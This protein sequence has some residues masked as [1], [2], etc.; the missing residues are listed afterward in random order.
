MLNVTSADEG[1]SR[2]LSSD[3][4]FIRER[5]MLTFKLAQE[6]QRL[7]GCKMQIARED[8]FSVGF[9]L[10]LRKNS[11]LLE[12]FNSALTLMIENGLVARWRN[13]YWPEKNE[14]TEC[15]ASS[16]SQ[17]VPLSLKHFLSIYLVFC[18]LTAIAF[19]VLVYQHGKVASMKLFETKTDPHF[20][21]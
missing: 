2:V 12:P 7:G 20:E 5:S 1:V 13:Q 14:F 3:W 18:I 11:P 21:N 17:A 10:A 15:K 4:A 19:V 6:H 8:F 16:L 9:G